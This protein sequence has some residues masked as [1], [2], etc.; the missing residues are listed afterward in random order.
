MK[1]NTSFILD[2][3]IGMD[4]DLVEKVEFIFK[5]GE[6]RVKKFIYPSSNAVRGDG[7]NDKDVIYLYW[8]NRDTMVF[9]TTNLIEMDTRIHV[10]D[11]DQN[12]ETDIIHIRMK[13]TL[14]KEG[15]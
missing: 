3:K 7:E 9:D 6:S 12:P 2:A 5:Q 14:F 8:K 1:Q 4:L 11:S 10:L 15:D 13:P